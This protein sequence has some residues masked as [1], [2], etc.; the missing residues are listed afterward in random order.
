MK[1]PLPNYYNIL[2]VAPAATQEAIKAAYRKL[3]V[4]MKMHPDLGGDHD[5]AAQINE[6][7]E[8]LG[9]KG[10]RTAYDGAYLLQRIQTAQSAAGAKKP[11]QAS[12]PPRTAPAASAKSAPN[13]ENWA[14]E[15]CCPLCRSPLPRAIGPQTRCLHC[16]SPLA[17]P[18]LLGGF[19]KELFGRR[20]SPRMT[21]NHPAT[22]YCAGKA[23]GLSVKMRDI[24]LTGLS[25]F[26]DVAFEPRQVLKL[27]DANMETVLIV[28]ACRKR[29]ANYSV[30]G[31]LLTVA[32]EAKSGVFVSATG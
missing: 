7:Y 30:H 32:F 29:G 5:V 20:L 10:K 3:M 14:A 21:K 8:V 28:V 31:K 9:D 6:A 25:F 19:G 2:K 26:S 16:R 17:P 18:P 24:S 15:G 13:P 4:T 23:Q 27:R 11:A 1:K 12:A 22:V